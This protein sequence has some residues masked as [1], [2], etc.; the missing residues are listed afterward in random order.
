MVTDSRFVFDRFAPPNVDDPYPLYRA[1]REQAGVC[2]ADAFDVW[3]V[4]GYDDVREVVTD[5]SRFSSSYLIRTPYAPA[6]GVTEILRQGHPEVRVLLNQDPPE[7][8][9]ARALVA[10]AFTPRRVRTLQPRV[11]E[12]TQ[13]L[14]D[15]FAGAGHAELVEQ[16]AL[17]LPLQVICELLGLSL[18]DAD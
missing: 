15:S 14:L 2:Y 10:K 6:A 18:E 11:W 4:T 3:V 12:I 5:A 7:H 8:G 13:R 16:F 9:R 17:P 1:A